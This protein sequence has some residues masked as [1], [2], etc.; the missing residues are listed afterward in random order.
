MKTLF[1]ARKKPQWVVE[2]E[3]KGF[4]VIHNAPRPLYGNAREDS[5]QMDFIQGRHFAALD[6]NG[7]DYE[8]WTRLN[9][10][11]NA[12]QVEWVAEAE[13][14]EIGLKWYRLYLGKNSRIDPAEEKYRQDVIDRGLDVMN[15][16]ETLQ[17]E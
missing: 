3:A 1:V 16:I 8:V 13:A 2:Q 7:A 11:L 9:E 4:T 17:D 5:W 10:E 12:V 6:P 14:Y 15:G